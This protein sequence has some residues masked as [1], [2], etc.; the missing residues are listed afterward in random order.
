[1]EQLKDLDELFWE[2]N[3]CYK[4]SVALIRIPGLYVMNTT[5]K[6]LLLQ[7]AIKAHQEEV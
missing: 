4:V 2:V 6:W 5:L 1:M 3:C 7:K